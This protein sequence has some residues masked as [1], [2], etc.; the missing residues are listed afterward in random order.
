MGTNASSILRELSIC[1][2]S[3]DSERRQMSRSGG[4]KHIFKIVIKVEVELRG[5]NSMHF[6]TAGWKIIKIERNCLGEEHKRTTR[7]R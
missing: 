2:N 3:P 1:T 6:T 4:T 5:G 7:A